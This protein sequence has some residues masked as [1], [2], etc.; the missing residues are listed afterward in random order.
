MCVGAIT[1]DGDNATLN[2]AYYAVAHFSRFVPHGSIHVGSNELE[3][4]PN[5]AFLTPDGK[6]V[7]VVANT[8]NFPRTFHI[9]YHGSTLTTT[10]QS[11]SVGTYIW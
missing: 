8:G 2:V 3:Q 10:L 6:V 1:L 11:E 7:L 5:S 4:L 9:A